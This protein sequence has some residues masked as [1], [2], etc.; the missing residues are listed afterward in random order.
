MIKRRATR[1]SDDAAIAMPLD[2]EAPAHVQPAIAVINGA[3]RKSA[4]V[5]Y[6]LVLG[7]IT[8]LGLNAVIKIE[9]TGTRLFLVVMVIGLALGAA[10]FVEHLLRDYVPIEVQPNGEPTDIWPRWYSQL[11]DPIV[12]R[13]SDRAPYSY[14]VLPRSG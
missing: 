4:P 10:S 9:A 1:L 12:Y 3:A 6:W 8:F 14:V 11:S 13:Q 7:L 5:G 2:L